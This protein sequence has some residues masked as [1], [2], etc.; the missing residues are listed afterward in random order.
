MVYVSELGDI[1][2]NHLEPKEMLDNIR[3]ICRNKKDIDKIA[4][5]KFNNE[6][7]DGKK[8][9]VYSELLSLTIDSI[10][11]LKEES[12]LDSFIGGQ[13]M[14]FLA[15]KINGLDDFELISFLVIK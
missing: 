11:D 8:M 13:T 4:S 15:D 2:I 14:S 7:R 3:H 10:I 1:L 9:E 12:E 5:D 6:T